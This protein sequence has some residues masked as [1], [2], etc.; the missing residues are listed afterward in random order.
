M[1]LPCCLYVCRYPIFVVV[2]YAVRVVSKER[3]RLACFICTLFN[4]KVKGKAVPVLN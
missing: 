1:T 2:F 3:Q 4:D